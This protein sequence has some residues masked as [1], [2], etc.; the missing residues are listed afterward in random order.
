MSNP[1]EPPTSKLDS[2]K[3][4]SQEELKKRPAGIYAAAAWCFFGIGPEASL[5]AQQVATPT[6]INSSLANVLILAGSLVLAVQILQLRT[7][8]LVIF[9]LFSA[10]LTMYQV[11][12]GIQFILSDHSTTAIELKA[13]IAVA[14]G[15]SAWYVL[16]PSFIRLSVKY[17]KIHDQ[18]ALEKHIQKKIDERK[19]NKEIATTQYRPPYFPSKPSLESN[20]LD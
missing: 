10:A 19:I 15:M 7:V 12:V 16:R 3:N 1:Y 2:S 17:R 9:G 18:E 6:E 13:F 5:I 4:W 14:C 11:I 20:S 8:W